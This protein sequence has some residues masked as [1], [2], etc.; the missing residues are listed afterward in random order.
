M[1]WKL[2]SRALAAEGKTPLERRG[3]PRRLP[4]RP[5]PLATKTNKREDKC[6]KTNRKGD[7]Y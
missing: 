5:A 6:R 3:T 4:Y 2:I 7:V 1:P